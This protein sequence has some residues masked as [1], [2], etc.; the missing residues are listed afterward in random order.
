MR[1]CLDND[2]MT[3]MNPLIGY[4]CTKATE[5]APLLRQWKS[6][7]S[8]A[9]SMKT[10]IHM[11][12]LTWTSC[13]YCRRF[14]DNQWIR[15]SLEERNATTA[16]CDNQVRARKQRKRMYREAEVVLENTE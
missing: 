3:K 8:G 10:Y 14:V 9:A 7:L 12:G 2:Q 6:T 15:K 1:S 5:V 13:A 16:T 11:R 4:I